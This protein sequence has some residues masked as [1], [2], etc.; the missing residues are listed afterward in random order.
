[1]TSSHCSFG[2]SR[3]DT[4]AEEQPQR[5]R[6]DTRGSLDEMDGC[7]D[8]GT[9]VHHRMDA[10]GH[11]AVTSV[12]HTTRHPHVR[13]AGIG[14]C[15]VAPRVTQFIQLKTGLRID[16]RARCRVWIGGG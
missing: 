1:M 15:P 5:E 3:D 11:D 2:I 4:V 13:E 14:R 6:P 12:R 16:Y 9:R 10:L 7:V 8:V